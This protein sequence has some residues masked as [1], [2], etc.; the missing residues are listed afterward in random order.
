VTYPYGTYVDILIPG[1]EGDQWILMRA[2]NNG[3]FNGEPWVKVEYEMDDPRR[4][5]WYPAALTRK[6]EFSHELA[7]EPP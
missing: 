7:Q 3:E 6:A 5:F 2:V 4:K 1:P